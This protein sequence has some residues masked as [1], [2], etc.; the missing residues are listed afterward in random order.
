[1]SR[2][3]VLLAG[4]LGTRLRE[5]T[6]GVIPKVL[7]PVL[8]RPF[9]DYKLF[10]LRAMGVDEVTILAGE[11]GSLVDSYCDSLPE[12]GIDVRV[13]QEGPRL[14]G[15]A[16]AIRRICDDLPDAFWV[17]YGDSYVVADLEAAESSSTDGSRQFMTVL[18]NCDEVETSNVN[19]E[20]GRVVTY[21]KPALPGRFKWIDYGLVRLR[22]SEFAALPEGSQ[23]DLGTV[24]KTLIDRRELWAWEVNDWFWDVGSPAALRRTEETFKMKDWEGLW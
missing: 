12:I 22:G 16:G 4:G 8:G 21:A 19:V 2:H 11:L 14:L 7:V 9:L 3:C 6:R 17:T 10:S 13:I 5:V 24:F 20:D 1:M 18:Q 23:L 15:T